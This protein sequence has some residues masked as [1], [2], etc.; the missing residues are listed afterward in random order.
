L[1]CHEFGPFPI[2]EPTSPTNT[3]TDDFGHFEALVLLRVRSAHPGCPDRTADCS[4]HFPSED[5]P[6]PT[7]SSQTRALVSNSPPAPV[8]EATNT[9]DGSTSARACA[10]RF[11]RYGLA[12]GRTAM[13]T[14]AL[15]LGAATTRMP[16]LTDSTTIQPLRAGPCC[17]SG[18]NSFS[19]GLTHTN[20]RTR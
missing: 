20:E 10:E 7:W 17:L 14:S 9:L 6:T 19:L 8:A 5:S 2:R 3:S 16:R 13:R 12:P 18:S 11:V 1:S 4:T 15:R